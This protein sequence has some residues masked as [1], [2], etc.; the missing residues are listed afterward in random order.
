MRSIWPHFAEDDRGTHHRARLDIVGEIQVHLH[1]TA[2]AEALRGQV[3]VANVVAV[4]HHV[5]IV[6]LFDVSGATAFPTVG[7]VAVGTGDGRS[8][9]KNFHRKRGGGI[10]NQTRISVRRTLLCKSE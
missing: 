8:R 1:V 4:S 7:L 3:Q 2:G 10:G 9:K 6:D 5:H